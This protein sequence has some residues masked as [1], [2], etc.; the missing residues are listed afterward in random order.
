MKQILRR[1]I[2]FL[3]L[4]M[5]MFTPSA[6]TDQGAL[7][8]FVGDSPQ[9]SESRRMAAVATTRTMMQRWRTLGIPM[10]NLM[11]D[12]GVIHRSGDPLTLRDLIAYLRHLNPA[13][14]VDDIVTE[15]ILLASQG[16]KNRDALSTMIPGAREL[17]TLMQIQDQNM[18]GDFLDRHRWS[19]FDELE[20]TPALA[21]G[22]LSLRDHTQRQLLT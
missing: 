1:S 17:T 9:A 2:L 20:I 7:K 6:V 12:M 3:L 10:G 5:M 8:G 22:H 18:I 14:V 19:E 11:G 13:A 15:S 4:A 16:A 21:Q